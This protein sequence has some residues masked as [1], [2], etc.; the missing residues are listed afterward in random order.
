MNGSH[1]RYYSSKIIHSALITYEHAHRIIP[2]R[3]YGGFVELRFSAMN[4]VAVPNSWVDSLT[5]T[6]LPIFIGNETAVTLPLY[7]F[8]S[9]SFDYSAASRAISRYI[10]FQRRQH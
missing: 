1:T 6:A 8:W 10:T 9:N 7:C 2:D 3:I 5:T 4:S